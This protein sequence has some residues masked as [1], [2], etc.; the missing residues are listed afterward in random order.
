MLKRLLTETAKKTD[1]TYISLDMDSLDQIYAPGVSAPTP[2]GLSPQQINQI[3][4]K[5]VKSTSVLGM[6][7][8][9]LN[10]VYDTAET[11]AINAANFLVQFVA[12][13]YWKRD[14]E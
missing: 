13:Y 8:V 12:S 1:A 4:H 11:T 6:D 9:E 7:I 2:D 3:I 5:I 10:P 14:R